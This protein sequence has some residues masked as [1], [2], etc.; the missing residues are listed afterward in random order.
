MPAPKLEQLSCQY[1]TRQQVMT[2]RCSTA[3]NH[4]CG[5]SPDLHRRCPR[6]SAEQRSMQPA[7]KA[8]LNWKA[9]LCCQEGFSRSRHWPCPDAL[10]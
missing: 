9:L 4:I 6:R 1:S 2:S 10:S 5:A 3:R 8:L 7:Q